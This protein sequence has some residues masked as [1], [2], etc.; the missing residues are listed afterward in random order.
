VDLF[1]FLLIV[2]LNIEEEPSILDL[3]YSVIYVSFLT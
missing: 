3:K 2:L 1:P